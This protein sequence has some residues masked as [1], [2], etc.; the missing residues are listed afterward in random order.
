[1]D[2]NASGGLELEVFDLKYDEESDEFLSH[3][4]SIVA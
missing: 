2:W 3:P 1:L 4:V